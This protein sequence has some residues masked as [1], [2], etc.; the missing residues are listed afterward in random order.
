MQVV[1]IHH[2]T[3]SVSTLDAFLV[4]ETLQLVARILH[5]PQALI[6]AHLGT[7]GI[8]TADPVQGLALDLAV[9]T[10][11]SAARLGVVGA[12]DGG[13]ASL[14][15]LVAG[16][17]FVALDNVG[18]LQSHLLAGSQAHELLLGL[19]L[20]VVALNPQLATE[21]YL[22][23]AVGLVLG[24]VHG[25][26]HLR[27]SL[28]IVGDDHFHGVEHGADSEGAGV[29]VVAQ[30]TLKEGHIVQRVN[31]RVANLLHEFLDTLGRV[32]ATAES[33]DGWHTGVVPSVDESLADECAQV[34]L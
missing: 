12:I 9:G 23:C 18:V 30:G 4:L 13:D 28:G 15:I 22:V 6:E 1:G 32:A 34:A 14:G 3:Q 7:Y 8:V 20:E 29:Q 24:V 5:L 17:L 21:L 27:L 25:G 16:V 19:L 26:Q 10:G 33:A 11:Q 31:L 2:Q